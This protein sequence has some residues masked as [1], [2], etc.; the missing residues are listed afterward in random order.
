M[1]LNRWLT[2]LESEESMAKAVEDATAAV[3]QAQT[4]GE[5]RQAEALLQI[6]K[7]KQADVA[8]TLA[9]IRME[10]NGKVSI[11]NPLR[12]EWK[13][14]EQIAADGIVGLYLEGAGN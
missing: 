10:H 3:K 5:K 14:A 1:A 6:A 7:Y 8:R 13:T 11:G 12:T 9:K 4:P 2:N